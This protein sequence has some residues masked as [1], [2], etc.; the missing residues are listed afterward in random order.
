MKLNASKDNTN[1]LQKR[2]KWRKKHLHTEH[3]EEFN[4]NIEVFVDYGLST[5]HLTKI[6]TLLRNTYN[7]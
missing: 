2:L 5:V 1:I 3:F 4:K 6:K 7:K